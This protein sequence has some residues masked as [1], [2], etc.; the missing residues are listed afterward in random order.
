[1]DPD[2]VRGSDTNPGT[3]TQPFLTVKHALTTDIVR[4]AANTI[5][6]GT[7]GGTDVTV[8]IVGAATQNVSGHISTR[9]LTRGSVTVVGPSGFNLKLNGKLL[10]LN[11]GY[12]LKGFKITSGD[13]DDSNNQNDQKQA[14]IKLAGVGTSLENM[15][16]DCEGL[17]DPG[18]NF[19]TDLGDRCIEVTAEGG[20]ITLEG[21]EV[22]IKGDKN[23]T[24]GIVHNGSDTTLRVVGS[25][26]RS[27]GS[28]GQGV[29]GV[30]GKASAGPVIVQSSTVDLES[31]TSGTSAAGGQVNIAVLLNVGDSE[32]L[33]SRIKLNGQDSS[34]ATKEGSIGVKVNHSSGLVVVEGT[35]FETQTDGVGIGI[36]KVIG[37]G[38]LSLVNN[39]FPPSAPRL[40]ENFFE[41]P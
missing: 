15:K 16:I 12:R 29:V 21:L 28:D 41:G 22:E 30:L 20:I 9:N 26:I 27:T 39:T 7:G 3:A 33:G 17:D 11:K 36:Y 1:V 8:T 18:T 10:T 4:A 38:S 40:H 34:Q 2:P 31:I 37:S 5:G 13:P 14:A 23:Y 6:S 19:T 35:T 32:V 25:T 24:A